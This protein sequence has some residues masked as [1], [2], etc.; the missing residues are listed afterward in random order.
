MQFR[1]SLFQIEAPS[2][3]ASKAQVVPRKVSPTASWLYPERQPSDELALKKPKSGIIINET[4]NLEVPSDYDSF[5]L[6]FKRK[7]RPDT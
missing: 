5:D 1:K 4:Q 7:P 6:V 2:P 3:E